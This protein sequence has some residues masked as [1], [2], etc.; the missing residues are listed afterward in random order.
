MSVAVGNSAAVKVQ[1]GHGRQSRFAAPQEQVLG[2]GERGERGGVAAG[3]IKHPV[4]AGLVIRAG[5]EPGDVSSVMQLLA[6][7][8]AA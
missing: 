7:T 5:Y 8:V 2:V 4:V 6:V 1:A 3:D